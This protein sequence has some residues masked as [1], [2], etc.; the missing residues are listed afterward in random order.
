MGSSASPEVQSGCKELERG[1]SSGKQDWVTD[2]SQWPISEP[3]EKYEAKVQCSGEAKYV[4][5]LPFVN[6]ELHAAYVLSTRGNCSIASV[7]TSAAMVI[8]YKLYLVRKG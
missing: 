3:V 1:L 4:N 8:R 6:G 5:D 7:D 2:E